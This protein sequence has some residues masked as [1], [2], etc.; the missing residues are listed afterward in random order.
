MELIIKIIRRSGR[1]GIR[2]WMGIKEFCGFVKSVLVSMTNIRELKL[3]SMSATIIN[4]VLFTGVHA[5]SFVLAIAIILGA[6]VIIQAM[7]NFPKFGIE[8]FLGNL[9][10]IIVAR[11]LG[12]L[13]TAMIVVSRS[14]TAIATEIAT[15]KQNKEL[16][17][18]ELMGIDTTLYIVIPRIIAFIIAIFS[19]IILFDIT[20]FFGGYLVARTTVYLP[21]GQFSEG[22][23]MAFSAN[24]LILTLI[25][26][27]VYGFLIPVI[28]CYYGFMPKTSYE[29]PIFV[30]KA[31]VRSLF[32]LFIINAVLSVLFYL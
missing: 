13:A 14:G 23:I 30:S 11:E 29:I 10:V 17:S 3:R 5:L 16:R 1:W 19:L 24:D 31:V 27:I 9:M 32:V 2:N 18:L 12:P 28:C 4:Q 26:S 22:L 7:K 20:A 21:M 8:E 15:Q 25:K 6:T